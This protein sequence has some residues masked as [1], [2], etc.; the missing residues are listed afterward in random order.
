VKGVSSRFANEELRVDHA[1]K[2]QGGYGAFTVSRW[3][4]KKVSNYIHN[5]KEH[6]ANEKIIAALEEIWE[7]DDD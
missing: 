5:Q 7:Q 3:D 4:V 6:H 2:W 1:F